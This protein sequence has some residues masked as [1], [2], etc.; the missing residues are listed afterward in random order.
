MPESGPGPGPAHV[1]GSFMDSV[2]VRRTPSTVGAE[3]GAG[4][5]GLAGFWAGNCAGSWAEG[6]A[7]GLAGCGLGPFSVS[8]L[9][10]LGSRTHLSPPYLFPVLCSSYPRRIWVECDQTCRVMQKGHSPLH[11]MFHLLFPSHSLALSTLSFPSPGVESSSLVPTPFFL[12][13]KKDMG[14]L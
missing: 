13:S 10:I 14:G 7:V 12:F 6:L 4:L 3:L 8:P 11:S 1:G 2:V 9:S 5:K